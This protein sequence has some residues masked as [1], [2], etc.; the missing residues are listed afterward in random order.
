MT[1]QAH[2]PEQEEAEEQVE[3][4]YKGDELEVGFN[5]SYLLDALGGRGWQRG[6]D[7]RDGRQLELPGARARGDERAV[8]RDADAPVRRGM[9][10]GT[11]RAERFRCLSA[12]E[13]ELDPERQ[14][15]RRPECFGQDQPARGRVFPEPR[16]FVSVRRRRD[17]LIAHGA[18][19][20]ML[21]GMAL[22]PAAPSRW[23][24]GQ[25]GRIPSGVSAA[26]PRRASR[27]WPSSFPLRSSIRKFTSFSRKA[28]ADGADFWT[29]VCST[30]NMVSCRTGAAI[31]RRSDN[32]TLR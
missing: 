25:R 5:V 31:I 18:D 10:L 19:D 23:V 6:G 12:I 11:F 20:F 3:V 8:C 32:A 29:G 14:P 15:V 13:L 2:N 16:S 21:T 24:S 26:R 30:W 22:G 27:I 17:A 28:R 9:P 1:L 4:N 7:R